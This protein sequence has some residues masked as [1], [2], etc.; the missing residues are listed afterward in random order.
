[1]DRRCIDRVGKFADVDVAQQLE[2]REARG[3]NDDETERDADR[4]PAQSPSYGAS[5]RS[6]NLHRASFR[7]RGTSNSDLMTWRCNTFVTE[8]RRADS[9]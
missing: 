8:L 3:G 7:R 9:A 4:F 1:M 2:E 5:N 6:R